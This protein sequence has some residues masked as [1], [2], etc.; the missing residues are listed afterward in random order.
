MQAVKIDSE[1]FEH[2]MKDAPGLRAA[3]EDL[4]RER[5]LKTMQREAAL[6][7]STEWAKLATQS[8]RTMSASEIHDVLAEHGAEAPGNLMG[9]ILMRYR[10]RL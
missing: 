8:I 6:M 2:L 10:V 5:V 9:N 4:K 3:V 1:D 7:D